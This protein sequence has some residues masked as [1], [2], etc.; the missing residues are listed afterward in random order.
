MLSVYV[1]TGVQLLG[2]TFVT[3][4][5]AVLGGDGTFHHVIVQ[6][7]HRLIT[8]MTASMTASMPASM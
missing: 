1:G 2:M 5:F 3:M 8:S 6:A 4:I 7:K